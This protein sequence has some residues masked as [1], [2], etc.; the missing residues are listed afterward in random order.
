MMQKPGLS[1]AHV[2]DFCIN[3]VQSVSDQY[4][5]GLG[6]G[7]L[8]PGD[9]SLLMTGAFGSLSWPWAF[10]QYGNP[11]NGDMLDLSM[12]IKGLD[13]TFPGGAALC[14]IDRLRERLEICMVENFLKTQETALT[15]RVWLSTLIFAHT[16]A[17]AT[18][19]DEIYVMNPKE[20]Y[21]PLY[22]KFGFY[23]DALC[24]PHLCATIGE[25]EDAL[26]DAMRAM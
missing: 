3:A 25:I 7:K 18:S 6:Y 5:W 14:R 20:R 19:H 12:R 8:Q 10:Q 23:E 22:R 1:P 13:D 2:H 17:K 24:M 15:K 21:I 26:K 9:L 16:V 4:G 11:L